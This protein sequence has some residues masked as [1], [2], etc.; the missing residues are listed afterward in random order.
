M[1][2]GTEGMRVTTVEEADAVRFVKH[3][4]EK[5]AVNAGAHCHG[6]H[7]AAQAA[8]ATQGPLGHGQAAQAA[9]AAQ[10]NLMAA[11]NAA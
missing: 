11:F 6:G 7:H 9:N 2:S 1:T 4:A 5:R 10:R 8:Q 3:E